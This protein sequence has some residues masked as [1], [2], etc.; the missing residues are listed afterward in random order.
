MTTNTTIKP[1]SK[2]G[3]RPTCEAVMPAA[4]YM[5]AYAARDAMHYAA[6]WSGDAHP[7]G[8][9]D[10]GYCLDRVEPAT[11]SHRSMDYVYGEQQQ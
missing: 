9:M 8:H 4:Y 7:V 2:Y 1:R 10:G 11:G 6:K 5:R 3:E